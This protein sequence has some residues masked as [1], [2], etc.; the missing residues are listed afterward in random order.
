MPA[1][2][3]L[4]RLTAVVGRTGLIASPAELL[5]Y[6]CDGYTIEKNKP[7]VVVFPTT[8]EQVVDIVKRLQRTRTSRSCRA[9]RAPASPA[10]ACPSA[11]AS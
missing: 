11:A 5:V 7:D 10:A 8:T 4:Q 1:A 9:A 6:E 2:D 3:L